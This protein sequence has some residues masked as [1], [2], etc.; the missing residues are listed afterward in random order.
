MSMMWTMSSN[1]DNDDLR[2]VFKSK[3]CIGVLLLLNGGGREQH[4]WSLPAATIVILV[5]MGHMSWSAPCTDASRRVRWRHDHKAMVVA[6]LETRVYS[7][8]KPDFVE[9]QDCQIWHYDI[10]V[11]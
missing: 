3:L 4:R 9:T 11:P 2:R 1:G 5:I 6:A 10:V 8:G 7:R